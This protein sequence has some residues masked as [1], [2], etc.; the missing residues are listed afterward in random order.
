MPFLLQQLP[1]EIIELV[2]QNTS[3]DDLLQLIHVSK[4]WHDFFLTFLYRSMT[5]DSRE[6]LQR[7][8]PAVVDMGHNVRS[9]A[10]DVPQLSNH[11]IYNL[12]KAFSDIDRLSWKLYCLDSSDYVDSEAP[13]S[14]I[15]P[16]RGLSPAIHHVFQHYGSRNLRHLTLNT[17]DHGSLDVWSI[18]SLCPRLKSLSLL[19]LNGE[20][21]ITLGYLETIHQY[22]PQLVSL[23]IK[24]NRSD[25]SPA[26]LPQFS[27]N[28]D[29][30]VLLPTLLESFSLSSKS[31]S[32]KWPLL[33][34]YFA[35]KYP[36]L[37]HV[38]FKHSG[39]G[40]E[41]N[42]YQLPER[43]YAMFARSC[44]HIKTMRWNKIQMH[45]DVPLFSQAEFNPTRIEGYEN[46]S[47]ALLPGSPL[48]HSGFLEV[49]TWLTIGKPPG[50]ITP[51]QVIGTLSRYKNLTHLKVQEGAS[52]AVDDILIHCPQLLSLDMKDVHVN[53]SDLVQNSGGQHPL[54][55]LVMKRASFT[56]DVLSH[57]SQ[58]CLN[59]EHVELL[60]CFQTDRRDQV[61][62]DLNRQ[63]LKTLK[64]QGLRTKRYYA[65]CR[66]RFFSVN[67]NN[68]SSWKYMSDYEVRHH[69]V[70]QK[71]CFEKYRE[72]EYAKRFDTLDER[73]IQALTSL[74]TT[75]TLKAWDIQAVK[76]RLPYTSTIHP[77]SWAPENIYYSGFVNI[78]CQSIENLI[79][80]QKPIL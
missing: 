67:T 80:N 2:S 58:Q 46:F 10:L 75:E 36:Y 8:L 72:M 19:N 47:T 39:L 53:V 1:F 55:R 30:I 71:K 25:P 23:T 3:I 6:K 18:L 59:L 38:L 7:I 11:D 56:Q 29:P 32:S 40:K 51:S 45:E 35:I 33:L 20:H 60:A 69:G 14:F 12:T 68:H 26:L 57:I 50:D 13:I 76:S 42:G 16:P 65:G 64:I 74:V 70:G 22:C 48:G 44:K 43:A 4:S 61:V 78:M 79:I 9:L 54:K 28:D 37:K 31:G 66:I 62:V 24:C 52:Y 77:A 73:D 63:K 21:V 5:M 15:H 27:Q 41:A 17:L 49:L 34:P